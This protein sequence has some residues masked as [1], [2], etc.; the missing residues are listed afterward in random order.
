MDLILSIYWTNA[1]AQIRLILRVEENPL[2]I[3][4]WLYRSATV[5]ALAL[6]ICPAPAQA[7]QQLQPAITVAIF[8]ARPAQPIPSELWE[9]LQSAILSEISTEGADLQPLAPFAAHLQILRADQVK[10]GIVVNDFITVYLHGDCSLHPYRMTA[11]RPESAGTL[12]WVERRHGRI[13]PFL[14]IDCDH[15]T[16]LLQRQAAGR[17]AEERN[18]IL[19]QAMARVLLHEWLHIATQSAHHAKEGIGR[20]HFSVADLLSKPAGH[21]VEKEDSASAFP[22]PSGAI[23]GK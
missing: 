10:L 4:E 6:A 11:A 8:N 9:P 12:G 16:Q 15:L 19:A 5:S 23:R 18:Q 13:E 20:A 2:R 17:D 7:L 1:F 3:V 22:S 14:H 21:P